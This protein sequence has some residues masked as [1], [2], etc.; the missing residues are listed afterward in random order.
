VA[1]GEALYRRDLL[2]DL[3]TAATATRE[4]VASTAPGGGAAKSTKVKASYWK[5]A[6]QYTA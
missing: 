6:L 5:C 2:D 3:L 4:A 1:A